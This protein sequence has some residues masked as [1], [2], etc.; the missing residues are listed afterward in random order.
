MLQFLTEAPALWPMTK[1]LRE[2]N[3]DI[4]E[5]MHEDLPSYLVEVPEQQLQ[6]VLQDVE[7]LKSFP[8]YLKIIDNIA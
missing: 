3:W 6:E 1:Y 8:E 2:N 5:A 4:L 7:K